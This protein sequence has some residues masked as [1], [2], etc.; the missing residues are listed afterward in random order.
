LKQTL[1]PIELPMRY[2][3]R[4]HGSVKG[5]GRTLAI[6]RRTVRFASDRDL[7][8]GLSVCL[9]ISWPAQLA[10]GAGLSLSMF[11]WI[12]QS[13][14][15]EVEVRVS[16]HEFRTRRGT[17]SVDQPSGPW[18]N[19]QFGQIAQIQAET[20]DLHAVFGQIAQKRAVTTGY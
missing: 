20:K 8:V 3:S 6:N 7:Q 1:Y 5:F 19:L 18:C 9:V 4:A 10:D 17:R 16:S 11:G 12:E 2:E 13:T 15:G 14:R